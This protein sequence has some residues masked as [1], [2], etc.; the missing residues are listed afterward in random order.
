MIC[1]VFSPH[2]QATAA[3]N[4]PAAAAA[5]GAPAYIFSTSV[6][7]L[8]SFDQASRKYEPKTTTPAGCVIVGSGT[9]YRLM[10]Y[11][12]AKVTLSLTDISPQV[13][14]WWC[15]VVC[16]CVRVLNS[17]SPFPPLCFSLHVCFRFL[18]LS[19]LSSTNLFVFKILLADDL[20]TPTWRR[21]T[22]LCVP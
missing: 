4:K 11:D 20:P 22:L 10:F 21:W 12:Q 18:T 8:Y 5:S 2:L 15:P 6:S 16:V 13:R 9:A 14:G 17:S 7:A 1:L 19:S 3:A